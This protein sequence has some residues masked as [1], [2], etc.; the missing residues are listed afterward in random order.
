MFR[1]YI[2]AMASNEKKSELR[3]LSIPFIAI[4]LYSS[5]F[6]FFH[7]YD[8]KQHFDCPYSRLA[9]DLSSAEGTGSYP[10]IIPFFVFLFLISENSVLLS[11]VLSVSAGTRSPP[12]PGSIPA[13]RT[14]RLHSTLITKDSKRR[15]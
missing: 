11:K 9:A 14:F 4:M 7:H 8:L 5:L 15:K 12:Q 2:L 3:G 6:T 10:A 1:N 13:G